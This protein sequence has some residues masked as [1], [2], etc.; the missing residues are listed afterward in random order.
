[1]N[2]LG[3][4]RTLKKERTRQAIA[5]A[6][7][8][9]F[10]AN[11]FEKVSVAEIA[12]AAEVSKPTLFRYFASKEELVLHRIADHRGE[13]GRVVRA[14]AAGESP[15]AALRRHFLDLLAD[16]DPITGLCALPEVLAFRRLVYET[17]SLS[18]HLLDYV[19]ADTEALAG[20]LAETAGAA[21]GQEG[22]GAGEEAGGGV[23]GLT[24]RLVAAQYL[25][26]HQTLAYANWARVAAGTPLPEA[27]VQAVADAET[28]F[29]LLGSGAAAYGY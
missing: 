21:G 3:G 17:P 15:L 14:R 22:N 6:A 19:A 26:A 23:P 5:D 9:L 27:A 13:A 28:A 1:M 7:I 4:L 16:R 25:A 8:R 2:E 20:A 18:S 10:L 11:G 29:A 12:A 24:A